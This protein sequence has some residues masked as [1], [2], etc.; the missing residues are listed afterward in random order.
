MKNK[1]NPSRKTKNIQMP[2]PGACIRPMVT[3]RVAN[4]VRNVSDS[5]QA[6]YAQILRW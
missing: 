5:E 3:L 6:A 4:D 1:L 2:F